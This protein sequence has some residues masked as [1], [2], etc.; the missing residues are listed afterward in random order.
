MPYTP[1]NQLHPRPF[2]KI[3]FHPWSGLSQFFYVF[4]KSSE[5]LMR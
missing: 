3:T 2:L 5:S 4:P 1:R